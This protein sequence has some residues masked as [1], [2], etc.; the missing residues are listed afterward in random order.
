MQGGGSTIFRVRRTKNSPIFDLRGR[1]IEEPPGSE[2]PGESGA[3]RARRYY[4]KAMSINTNSYT[5]IINYNNH[6]NHSYDDDNDNNDNDNDN[7]SY[8]YDYS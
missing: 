1:K 6:D 2:I 3:L 8:S 5:Q 7:D 4:T